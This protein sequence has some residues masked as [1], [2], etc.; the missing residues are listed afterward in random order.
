MS[1]YDLAAHARDNSFRLLEAAVGERPQSVGIVPLGNE[2]F[3]LKV[4]FTNRPA[5]PLPETIEGFT[6]S[7]F[8]APSPAVAFGGREPSWLTASRQRLSRKV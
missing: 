8:I 1:S 5:R 6:V 7:Y 3:G 2:Q 4:T